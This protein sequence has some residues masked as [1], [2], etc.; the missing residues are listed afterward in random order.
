MNRGCRGGWW[1]GLAAL[2]LLF[3]VG[4]CARQPPE[5][6]Q[7]SGKR[8]IVTLRFRSPVNPN[9]HYFFLINNA[10]DQNAPGPVPVLIPPYGNG[11]A[12]GSGGG[13]SG[14]TDFVRFDNLQPQGYGL[15]HAVGDPNRSNFVY[16]G[17][18]LNAV[19]PDP[20]DP[21]TAS[22]LQFEIDLSQLITDANGAP[23]PDPTEAA[24]RARQIRFLQVNVVATNIVPRDVTTPVVKLVDSFGD[25]RTLAG[26]SSFL[27]LD[28]S[29]NRIV[30]NSDFTG[31]LIEEPADP[32]VFVGNDPT[33]DLVDWSIEVR[34]Q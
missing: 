23:L 14:F 7:L 18:P 30:R 12:T 29:Q 27:V 34:Q 19:L 33:L 21:R 11:F 17:R 13:T 9:Y 26:A 4:G 20:T 5:R 28:V 3:G 15:Y 8:L 1:A 24:N 10:G 25:T 31:Q 6:N 16:E 2:I 22:Q 32:D